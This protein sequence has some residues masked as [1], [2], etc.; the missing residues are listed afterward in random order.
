[1]NASETL[2]FKIL[3]INYF[4]SL[5]LTVKQKFYCLLETQNEWV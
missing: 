4:S 3:S 5:L 2:I 1:M